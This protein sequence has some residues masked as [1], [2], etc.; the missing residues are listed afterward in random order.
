M[1]LPFIA[2]NWKW[3]K[4]ALGENVPKRKWPQE[5]MAPR[6]KGPT[7][8]AITINPLPITIAIPISSLLLPI[9]TREV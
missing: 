4:M 1:K 7:T 2:V 9:T 5:K 6:K 3:K 8:S